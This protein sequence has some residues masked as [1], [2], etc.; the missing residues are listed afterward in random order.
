[1]VHKHHAI[2]HTSL[3]KKTRDDC[4]KIEIGKKEF[5]Q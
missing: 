1:M 4:L 5:A 3:A 2:A